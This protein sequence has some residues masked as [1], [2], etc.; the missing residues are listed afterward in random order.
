MAS[1]SNP[2]IQ[3]Y[4]AGGAIALG[5]AVKFGADAQTVVACEATTDKSIGIAQNPATQAGDYVE[6]ALPGGGAKAL[7]QGAIAAGK[8]LT[9]HTDGSLK[10][11][12]AAND[13]V[14]AMAM[15]SGVAND[16]IPVEV[17]I[18]QGTAVEA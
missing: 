10:P 11:V 16:L 2:R 12:A 14:V 7:C 3:T 8:L 15:D 5:K 13:R 1:I 9:S 17:L 6:V 18:C 4:K